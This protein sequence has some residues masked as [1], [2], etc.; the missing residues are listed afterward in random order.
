MIFFGNKISNMNSKN[1][2][3]K[4]YFGYDSL[5][6]E[7]SKIIDS[8][9]ANND[10]IGLLPTGYGKSICFNIPAL[11]LDG[12]T[13]VIT[14]LIS[15]MQDQ[16]KNLKNKFIK[17]EYINSLQ[18]E[19]EKNQIYNKLL[20]DKIKI[21]FVSG[22]RLLNKRFIDIVN[23]IKI[24]LIVCDEAH[25]LLWSED[26]RQSLK[27]I[28]NFI[29]KLNERPPILALTATATKITIMKITDILKLNNPNLIIGDCDRKNI[30]YRIIKTNNKERSLLSY[31]SRN[32][33]K[34]IIYTLTIKNA[35]YLY[36]ELKELGYNV[37]LYH[38]ELDSDEK[39]LNQIN[40]TNGIYNLMVATNAFGMGIDIPDIR[41]VVEYDLPQSIE[42]FMQQTGR[43][44]RDG[45]YAEG[46]LLFDIRDISTNEYFIDN[47]KND[48]I[49]NHELNLIKLDRYQK[50]DRMIELGLSKKCIHQLISEYFSKKHPGKCNMC[51]NC[52]K[53]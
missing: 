5:K 51:S 36:Y 24:S 7:Q 30:F 32:K 12:L 19:T 21:L 23:K 13:L 37:G 11:L 53:N 34:G 46:V 40:F 45:K 26:F 9:L 44:S 49:D 22:E 6:E 18:T 3:L 1:E 14:P 35:E 50:L 52:K 2:I 47:I 41:F 20:N 31:L 38:G 15:L 43:G 25:T 29:E 17:A 27:Y 42:D 10:T 16:V 48:S 39:K 28:P 33:T 4:Y 8:V